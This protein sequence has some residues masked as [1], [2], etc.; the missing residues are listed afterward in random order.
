MR[1]PPS[2]TPKISSIFW[3]I[4]LKLWHTTWI[5]ELCV[6]ILRKIHQKCSKTYDLGGWWS[7]PCSQLSARGMW[8]INM[9][10][11]IIICILALVAEYSDFWVVCHNFKQNSSK[12][13]ISGGWWSHRS[14]QLSARAL[15]TIIW[16]ILI[17]SL[18]LD[19]PVASYWWFLVV[20]HNFK[21]NHLKNLTWNKQKIKIRSKNK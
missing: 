9:I 7:H 15:W 12:M 20:C 5:F 6:T 21:R 4:C 10:N 16:S 17:C 13:L 11:P 3:W 19:I 2:Q 1:P 14:S 18:R 8:S